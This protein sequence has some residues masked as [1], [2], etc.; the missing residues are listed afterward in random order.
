MDKR[1]QRILRY[2]VKC[3]A[4][5]GPVYIKCNECPKIH[6]CMKCFSAGAELGDHLR[7]HEY[8]VKETA[9]SLAV[10]EPGWS[11]KD[12]EVLLES[13]EQYGLGNWEGAAENLPHKT[14]KEIELHYNKFYVGSLLGK[15]TIPQ[16]IPNRMTDHTPSIEESI[17]SAPPPEVKACSN[18]L[19]RLAYMPKRDDYEFEYDN[20]AEQIVCLLNDDPDADQVEKS[21]ATEMVSIYSDRL[22][23]RQ[24]R[25]D[26]CREYKLVDKFFA[27]GSDEAGMKKN[28]RELRKTLRPCSQFMKSSQFDYFINV[29]TKERQL[30]RRIQ[31]LR[32]YRLNGITRLEDCNAFDAALYKRNKCKEQHSNANGANKKNDSSKLLSDADESSTSC[33]QSLRSDPQWKLLCANERQ[34]C[35]SLNITPTRFT[36][37]KHILYKDNTIKKHDIRTKS[38]PNHMNKTHRRQVQAFLKDHGWLS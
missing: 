1:D 19:M 29:L 31:Q 11:A 10:F 34:F 5:L 23:E 32:T 3:K 36:A 38:K 18:D 35:Q 24:R 16:D 8:V 13:I 37:Y 14:P 4:D 6:L 28:E 21:L 15:V 25:K 22:V 33:A 26:I 27:K 30:K 7:T 2:C 9:G 12:E 17:I 20:D